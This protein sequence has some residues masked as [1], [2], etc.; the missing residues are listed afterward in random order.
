M[1]TIVRVHFARMT[2]TQLAQPD[3]LLQ[4]AKYGEISISAENAFELGQIGDL[5]SAKVMAKWGGIEGSGSH[6]VR[7]QIHYRE[8][9]NYNMIRR[10]SKCLHQH[11]VTH[12]QVCHSNIYYA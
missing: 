11:Y 6:N 12:S 7:V 2:H 9:E 10:Y 1:D 3:E 8:R 5:V 4:L